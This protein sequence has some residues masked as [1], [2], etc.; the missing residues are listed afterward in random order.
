MVG[1][2][3][4]TVSVAGTMRR[5]D[6]HFVSAAPDLL[7]LTLV[8]LAMFAAMRT[9]RP[10]EPSRAREIAPRL[11][12]MAAAVHGIGM[13]AFSVWYLPS[14]PTSLGIFAGLSTAAMMALIGWS[15]ARVALRAG[16]PR[17]PSA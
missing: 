1:V 3:A 7:S 4:V 15:A 13:A 2:F 11:T 17:L 14:H 12:A 6:P 8:C 5:G 16:T 10:L 9:L